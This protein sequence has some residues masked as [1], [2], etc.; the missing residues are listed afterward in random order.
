MGEVCK[1]T[2]V[3]RIEVPLNRDKVSFLKAGDNVLLN[4]TVYTGS[5]AAQQKKLS[6]R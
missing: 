6:K 4:G 5:G 1:M 2:N 3:I